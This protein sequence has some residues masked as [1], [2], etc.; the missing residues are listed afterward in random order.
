M[1]GMRVFIKDDKINVEYSG[2]SYDVTLS[3]RKTMKN[4]LKIYAETKY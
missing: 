1:E 4:T 3:V 2:N